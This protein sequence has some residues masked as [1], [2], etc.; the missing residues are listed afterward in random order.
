MVHFR[1]SLARL[2]EAILLRRSQG[3]T[4]YPGTVQLARLMQKGIV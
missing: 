1:T 3:S 4:S 2:A